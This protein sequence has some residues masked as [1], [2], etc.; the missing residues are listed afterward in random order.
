MNVR[1][2]L[3]YPIYDGA[4]I[5][6]KAPCDAS[7]VTGLIVYYP[8][9]AGE[10]SSVFTFADAHANDLGH[11]DELFA[12]GAV[13]KVILDTDTSM[14]FVQN[15]ATNAY[16]E[17][18]FKNMGGG[19]GGFVVNFH[20]NGR[21][22]ECNKSFDEISSALYRGYKVV[23]TY[24]DQDEL[25]YQTSTVCQSGAETLCFH[26]SVYTITIEP[27][28]HIS[29][30]GSGSVDLSNY[31]TKEEVNQLAGELVRELDYPS[32]AEV[33]EDAVKAAE[34]V[35]NREMGDLSSAL[36]HIIALQEELISL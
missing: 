5:V 32:R 1:V 4:E 35:V 29:V 13:V 18:K 21:A 24:I 12:A 27:G 7:E 23:A 25:V 26:F 6:F 31:Y 22:I 14:A 28:E 34:Y 20:Y 8:S 10:V 2:N 30:R 15:A 11:I 9:D 33:W 36:D 19:S 3:N 17:N 16:L